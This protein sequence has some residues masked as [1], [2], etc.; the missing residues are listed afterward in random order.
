MYWLLGE[1]LIDFSPGFS[2]NIAEYIE[3]RIQNTADHEGKC[4]SQDA[5]NL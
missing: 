3:Y 4:M 5:N 1:Q 2:Y